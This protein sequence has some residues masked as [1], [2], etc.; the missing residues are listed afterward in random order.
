MFT[1]RGFIQTSGGAVSALAL[2]GG[3]SAAV[4]APDAVV[5]VVSPARAGAAPIGA[6]IVR[7]SGDRIADLN[8]IGEKLEKGASARLV[9]AL[10]A[11]D[12]VLLDVALSRSAPAYHLQNSAAGLSTFVL[13]TAVAG[14]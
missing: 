12:E 5:A 14:V 10:D 11:A 13:N 7:L 8:L 4:L 2:T 1:R 6:D 3:V 9:F